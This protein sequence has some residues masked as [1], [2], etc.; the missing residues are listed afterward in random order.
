MPQLVV[1]GQTQSNQ[2]M[3]D[4]GITDLVVHQ[5]ASGPVLYA[6]SGPSGGLS[7]YAIAANGALT[8]VDYAHFHGSFAS[9]VMAQM[10][11][12]DTT[13]GL[14]L[15]VAGTTAGQLTAYAI[16]AQGMI[17]GH[18]PITGLASP[19]AA[20]LDIDQW[21]S[22]MLFLANGGGGSIQGYAIEGPTQL[23][24]RF[25]VGDTAATYAA[26]VFAL[27]TV[28]LGGADYLLGACVTDRGVTAYRIGPNGLVATGNL[29]VAEGIGIMTPTTLAT[30]AIGA[31]QFVLLGSAPAEGAGRSGAITVME[32]LPDGSLIPTDHV[33]DTLHTRFGMIQTLDVI[34][35]NGVTYVIAAGGDEGL[36]LFVLLPNGRL[37]LIDVVT[38]T[39]NG[40]LANVT[41]LA[42]V[43]QGTRLRMF[44][45]SE[46]SAGI[47]EITLDT[48]GH[49]I[50]LM[51]GTGPAQL[52][53]TAKDDIVIG[54]AG[55]DLLVGG[56][57]GDIIE[58]GGGRDTLTGGSG[59]DIFILRAD[60]QTDTIT[61][62]EP[63][64]DRLDLSDWP[65]LY[66]PAR[67]TVT[68]TATG[69][70]VTWRDE[71]LVIH[72][73]NGTS[74]SAA[75][76]I[77]A[78]INSPNRTPTVFEGPPNP[79]DHLSGSAGHDRID[80]GAGHDTIEGL[81]GNDTLIG[82]TGNDRLDGGAGFDLLYGGPG[83]DHLDGGAQADNLY[84]EAGND[85]LLGGD[86][87]DRL[88]GGGG[89]DSL[90][91]GDGSDALFAQE[92]HDTL[93]GDTGDDRLFGGSGEDLLLGGAGND[94][95][96]GDAG[97]DT[98]HGG[99]GNDLLYGGAQSDFLL[100][101]EGN[102][103]LHGGDG[104]DNVDGGAGND[105]LYGDA[106]ND[107]LYGGAG[108]DILYGGTQEDRLFGED[109]NDT[110]Y[111]GAGFDLLVGGDGNDYLD[112][113]AQADNLYGDAGND[114]LIG[115]GG[116]DRLFGGSGEDLLFGGEG[117][118]ALFGDAGNDTLHGDAGKDRMFGGTGNDLLFGGDGDDRI[119][120]SAG[121]D[122]IVGGAGNDALWG[123]FN[124]D[125]FVFTDGHGIDTIHDFDAR[126]SHERIDLTGLSSIGSIHDILGPGGAAVQIGGHV[127]IDTGGGNL[128]WLM[129]VAL[130][131]L[132]ASDFL[133]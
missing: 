58:D 50:T 16:S 99:A 104:M 121:F 35:A 31:R 67:L 55:N 26:T 57:G 105:I 14:Q 44:I 29:G 47:T 100:G 46:L 120:G 119:N 66:D 51:A 102:D 41:A 19:S 40:G 126:N 2:T 11:M 127:R 5:T 115:G 101:D 72:T 77:A 52:T 1:Q 22:D 8:L 12:L 71:T 64:R 84:G 108:H 90:S 110:L 13:N 82:G 23:T 87:N 130:A 116:F 15:V 24:E 133:F 93:Q 118:D 6:T 56:A 3:L 74:L 39:G 42:S 37:Q 21:G 20:V 114:R 88:F 43:H 132:D 32:L 106:S 17:E 53:G 38:D 78:L 109:G 30:A 92:G 54:G 125:I 10:A 70:I 79:D 28:A 107:R 60:G 112:A 68:P 85:T 33:I 80:G 18:A 34:E 49:G 111:G 131:D 59:R 98:L 128:I 103:T 48:S 73:M 97:F 65:F 113:G 117:D 123:G 96:W 122:T 89:N 36:T 7:A 95:L 62:F 69:A 81:T 76:V 9:S 94:T 129:N 75:A 27:E 86:G 4:H 124:A 61:D 91:G 83:N 63:G 25:G 45:T